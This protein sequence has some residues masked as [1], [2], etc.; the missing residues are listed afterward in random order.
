MTQEKDREHH[1]PFRKPDLIRMLGQQKLTAEEWEQLQRLSSILD[2]T[3]HFHY[4]ETLEDL[5]GL[6]APFDPDA[7]PF[8]ATT[9]SEPD[10]DARQAQFFKRLQSLVR[11]GNF[12]RLNW[13][14]IEKA[15]EKSSDWGINVDI[16]FGIIERLAIF[17]RGD[18]FGERTRRVWWKFFRKETKQ[19]PIYRRLVLAIKLKKADNVPE[20][21]DTND[22]FVKYFKDI[23]KD[24]ID[25]LLP[26]GNLVMP[27]LKRWQ[28]Q[29][30]IA[31]TV[32]F[33]VYKV[34]EQLDNFVDQFSQFKLEMASLAL[35]G[36]LVGMSF[37]QYSSYQ[38]T[39]TAYSLQLSKSLYFQNLANNAGVLFS[40]VDEAEE[41]DFREALLGYFYL[42]RASDDLT[43]EELDQ[44]IE[45]ELER[46][47]GV[48][49]DFEV[50]DALDKLQRL[51][52]V[53]EHEGRFRAVPIEQALAT[54]DDWWDGYFPYA[55]AA[56]EVEA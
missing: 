2:A 45:A 30:S 27:W 35:L 29:A 24:D 13:R 10:Q 50:T 53:T 11:R 34:V 18:T 9:V 16:D 4:H 8:E 28:L 41:Q 21:L 3:F 15:L 54:L 52:L 22:I 56:V 42:W 7:T 20:E 55:D 39:R 14:A 46:M 19:V 43:V 31:S 25:M 51:N 26:A 48:K 6:Y 49:V 38:S 1:I 36:S 32:A 12:T 5:K 17:V 40:L 44:R 37:R 33:V 47:G 23:P